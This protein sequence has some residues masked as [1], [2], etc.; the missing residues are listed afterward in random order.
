MCKTDPPK[1]TAAIMRVFCDPL[2]TDHIVSYCVIPFQTIETSLATLSA[3]RLV[4]KDARTVDA[5]RHHTAQVLVERVRAMELDLKL[6]EI[7]ALFRFRMREEIDLARLLYLIDMF[8]ANAR[9]LRENNSFDH[10]RE[11]LV[12]SL[13]NILLTAPEHAELVT[14]LLHDITKWA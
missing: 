1:S 7:N 12:R 2:L 11:A 10:R 6:L 5:I 8:R 3:M 4:F 9:N 13:V 14:L